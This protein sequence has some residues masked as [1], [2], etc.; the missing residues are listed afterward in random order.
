MS[1]TQRKGHMRAQRGGHS[2]EVAIRTPRRE[3]SGEVTPAS[4][5]IPGLWLL[6]LRKR[7]FLVFTCLSLQY[8][9][10]AEWV[11]ENLFF[12][13]IQWDI[14]HPSTMKYACIHGKYLSYR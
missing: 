14:M 3:D 4:T 5:S 10:M 7:K 12:F 11:I 6:E 9:F 8:F 13:S 1:V 2:E